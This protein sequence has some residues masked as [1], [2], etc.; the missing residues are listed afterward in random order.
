MIKSIKLIRENLEQELNFVQVHQHQIELDSNFIDEFSATL[1]IEFELPIFQFRNHDYTWMPLMKI[2]YSNWYSPKIIKLQNDQLIQANQHIGVWEV[3]AK[4]PKILFWH[5]NPSKSS[6]IAKYDSQYS[7]YIVEAQSKIKAIQPLA[8]MFPNNH[9]IEISRSK[10]PFSSIACFTDHCDFDTLTNLKQQRQFF[11]KYQIKI[12]KGFFLNDFSKRSDTA[13]FKLHSEELKKWLEEGHELAY[14]SISQS[15]KPLNEGFDDFE[16]FCPPLDGISSWIDHGFQPYNT[17][18]YQNHERIKEN[19]SELLKEKK[20]K[21]FWNY[22]DSGTVV[23]GVINQLNSNQFTLGTYYKGIK[24]LKAKKLLPLLIK[25]IIFHY[26]NS[27]DSLKLYRELASYFKDLSAKKPVKKHFGVIINLFKLTKLLLPIFFFW[28]QK[29]HEVYPLARYAPV[30]FKQNISGNTFTVFQTIEMVDFKNGLSPVNLD[31]FI[32]ERGLFIAHT[33]FSAP[34]NY[35]HGKLFGSKH[36]IDKQV[37]DNF[38]YLSKKIA[39]ND[40]WNPTLKQL[41]SQLQKLSEVRF[42]CNIKGEITIIDENQLEFRK[43]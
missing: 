8:L 42:N 43:V 7:K 2:Q 14:H 39:S 34:M 12:T 29:K 15:I 30:T 16:A 31:I 19:Y 4:T 27:D 25:N 6:P 28:K 3:N 24:H 38:F 20:I 35:H 13:S 10:I 41:I 17:S 32:K 37:D 5:F 26:Y 9:G 1:K 33:Y 40:I 23:Q 18:L 22:I 36:K 11:N 21:T